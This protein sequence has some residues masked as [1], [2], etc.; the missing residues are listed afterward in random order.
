M[1]DVPESRLVVALDVERY[2]G[3]PGDA[4]DEVRRALDRILPDAF[5]EAR[6]DWERDVVQREPTGDGD[7]LVLERRCLGRLDQFVSCLDRALRRYSNGGHQPLRMRM[8]V[9]QGPLHEGTGV[10][11]GKNGACRI[12]EED[13]LRQALR[14]YDSAT[15][16]VAVS[17]PVF[18]E[19]IR[20]GY[21]YGWDPEWF[22]PAET[23]VKGYRERIWVHVP[24]RHEPPDLS[25]EPAGSDPRP[26]PEPRPTPS[27]PAASVTSQYQ[28]KGSNVA[29]GSLVYG[30]MRHTEH[31]GQG[32]IVHGHKGD[33]VHGR[34][35]DDVY[36]DK[37][38]YGG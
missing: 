1:S 10:G 29:V 32:D 8:A 30:G 12:V 25:L 22:A 2:T 21:V 9:H 13:L 38:V 24:G 17:D 19:A 18:Q 11:P 3:R 37:R 23:D 33:V 16:V 15:L 35:G 7:L 6:L 27:A 31:S 5:E 4:Q 14:R 28:V 20:P 34:K 26:G 36:G